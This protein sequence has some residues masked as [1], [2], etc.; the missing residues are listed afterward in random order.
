M[1]QRILPRESVYRNELG[2]GREMLDLQTELLLAALKP[3]RE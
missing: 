3:E 2:Y 1:A